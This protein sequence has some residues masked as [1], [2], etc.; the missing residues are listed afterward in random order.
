MVRSPHP[1]GPQRGPR[2]GQQGDERALKAFAR[3]STRRV[4]T[5]V[6]TA[7]FGF[8]PIDDFPRISG[9]QRWSAYLAMTAD[10]LGQLD[11]W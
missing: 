5:A 4:G 9:G 11:T 3:R 7:D 8:I 2:E 10:D 1:S 6:T